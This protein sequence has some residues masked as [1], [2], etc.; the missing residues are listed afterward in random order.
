MLFLAL[1]LGRQV[2]RLYVIVEE[3]YTS[4]ATKR[5]PWLYETSLSISAP[6]KLHATTSNLRSTATMAS[7]FVLDW[8]MNIERTEP[9]VI[10]PCHL[11]AMKVGET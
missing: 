10:D 7:V 3:Q 9:A 6:V 4:A 1:C 11:H 5:A 2:L 8:I